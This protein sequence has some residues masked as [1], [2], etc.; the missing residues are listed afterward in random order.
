MRSEPA[1]GANTLPAR[2]VDAVVAAPARLGGV[3][4]VAIDG[5]SG[6][7]KS[8]LADRLVAVLRAAGL[9]TALV[10]TDEFAT[11]D[12]PVSWWPRLVDGVL[13][14]LAAG[15]PGSYRRTVWVDGVPRLAEEADDGD[16]TLEVPD[17][18]LI[19]GV[20][21]GR[22]SVR[23]KLSVLVWCE[24]ADPAL[25]LQRAVARDGESCREPLAAWQGFEDGWFAIDDPRSSAMFLVDVPVMN[26]PN[27]PRDSGKRAS[28]GYTSW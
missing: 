6:S 11:W 20:S 1:G 25:R 2:F 13:T 3:R 22:V 24:L 21:A 5:P 17:V 15:R 28:S 27:S 9:R 10:R 19:E 18:L 16:V 14:P 8:W 4:L 23:P 7:G 26:H 12:E